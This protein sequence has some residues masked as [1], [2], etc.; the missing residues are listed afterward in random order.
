MFY[1]QK[2]SHKL[3]NGFTLVEVMVSMSI[4]TMVATVAVGVLLVMVDANRKSQNIQSA[5]TNL[6]F[7]L[8]SM[9]RDIRTGTEYFCDGSNDPSTN[10][11]A[12]SDCLP[13]AGGTSMSF[14]EGGSSLTASCPSGSKRISFRLNSNQIERRL[15]VGVGGV[16]WQPITSPKVNITDMQ[17]IVT[18]S[19]KSDTLSPTATIFISGYVVDQSGTDATFEIETSVTQQQLDL[20]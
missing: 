11:S 15:C 9:T 17:F 4:F 13:G 16:G 10:A 18:G 7:A 12:L 14:N 8:D 6:S 1:H 5:M 20:P 19:N 3:R 2:Q